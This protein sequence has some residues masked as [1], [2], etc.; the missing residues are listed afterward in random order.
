MYLKQTIKQ[1]ITI[2][3]AIT[4]ILLTIQG[5][6]AIDCTNITDCVTSEWNRTVGSYAS[7]ALEVDDTGSNIY[8]GNLDSKVYA[9]SSDGDSTWN[10]TTANGVQTVFY[11]NN[12]VYVGNL[13]NPSAEGRM[14][15]LTDNGALVWDKDISHG[16]SIMEI[17]VDDND[18]IYVVDQDDHLIKLYSNG[19]QIWSET[20]PATLGGVRVD[21]NGFFYLVSYESGTS[22]LKKLDSSRNSIWNLSLGTDAPLEIKLDD[23]GFIYVETTSYQKIH[24]VNPNGSIVWTY[25]SGAPQGKEFSVSG[26][27]K[28]IYFGYYTGYSYLAKLD[29]E[30]NRIWNFIVTSESIASY[31]DEIYVGRVQKYTDLTYNST[32]LDN[33]PIATILPTTIYDDTL[34]KGYCEINS[35]TNQ[36]ITINATFYKNDLIYS[37]LETI[38]LSTNTEYNMIDVLANDTEPYDQIYL[39]CSSNISALP[40]ITETKTVYP[41]N[42]T[43]PWID[44]YTISDDTPSI[45]QTITITIIETNV[46]PA[47]VIHF[48]IK[49]EGTETNYTQNSDGQFFCTYN[50]SGVRNLTIAIS[51]NFHVGTW[52]NETNITITVSSQVFT[53]GTLNVQVYDSQTN[54]YLVGATVT[55]DEQNTTTDSFGR[56]TITTSEETTYVVK[57][58]KTGYYDKYNSILANGGLWFVYVDPLTTIGSTNI[59]IT[60]E[61]EIGNRLEEVIVSYTNTLTYEYDY[62]FT[63]ANGQVLFANVDSGTAIIQ[64]SH[65]DYDSNDANINIANGKTTE[66][67]ITITRIGGFTG[68]THYDRNCIDDGLW[69]CGDQSIVQHS[70]TQDSDCELTNYCTVGINTCS[71][72][73]YSRCDDIGMPRTQKCITKLTGEQT[74]NNITNWMLSNLL[75]VIVIIILLVSAGMIFISWKQ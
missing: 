9:L 32:P 56:A 10:Y 60:I 55:A 17:F 36:T 7:R 49:C 29:E 3:I 58:N 65:S 44:Y 43:L 33:I 5:G 19:T 21:D 15:K 20:F 38:N 35:T 31:E 64:A 1:R 53:G 37:T 41:Y 54:D 14:I 57:I 66:T 45:N 28:N 27:G 2:I 46:E 23:Y 52:N 6:M 12:Y 75:W 24:K 62:E 68:T 34:I 4:M 51:D 25:S 59:L 13:Q 18:Y 11:K 26:N 72:F 69:I 40:T 8:V 42:N 70:C 22:Y 71:R 74:L 47:D 48:G 61:D 30:G 16:T 63:D 39:S 73:N 50:S 67:T